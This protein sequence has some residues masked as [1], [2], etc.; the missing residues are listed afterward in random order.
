MNESFDEMFNIEL[1][2]NIRDIA[3]MEKTEEEAVNRS[4]LDHFL[5]GLMPD[6]DEELED[7]DDSLWGVDEGIVD[8]FDG[9]PDQTDDIND[10]EELEESEELEEFEDTLDIDEDILKAFNTLFPK[11]S[12][13]GINEVI[14]TE[15]YEH[16]L[17]N[18]VASGGLSKAVGAYILPEE[19]AER[20]AE[21]RKETRIKNIE[22]ELGVEL[23]NIHR[24]GGD[25]K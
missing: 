19:K 12:R 25:G 14:N 11:M 18:L 5:D 2:R 9:F 6:S 17:R 1:F 16:I 24:V 13:Y 7:E 21:R 23:R 4:V 10:M 20:E 22:A 8:V 15:V 3:E